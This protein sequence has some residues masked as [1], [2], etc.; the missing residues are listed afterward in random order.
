MPVST[1]EIIVVIIIL[2]IICDDFGA[3]LSFPRAG[4]SSLSTMNGKAINSTSHHII[5]KLTI[6]CTIVIGFPLFFVRKYITCFI[7][8]K[9]QI[10]YN[11]PLNQKNKATIIGFLAPVLWS[12]FALLA[13]KAGN[14]APFQLITISFSCSFF[15][16]LLIWKK[17]NIHIADFFKLPFKYWAIGI[18]GIFGFN[19]LYTIALKS[20][21]GAA[22]IFL[23][24]S[25]WPV[26]LIIFD[27]IFLKEHLK[28]WH[29][30]G[31]VLGFCGIIFIAIQDGFSGFHNEFLIPY[32]TALAAAIIWASYSILCKKNPAI[33]NNMVG[34]YTGVGAVLAFF[35]HLFFEKT[36]DLSISQII[37]VVLIGIGPSG[38]AYYAWNYGMRSGDIRA[39]SSF[40]FISALG[41]VILLILFGYAEFSWQ[42]A[43]ASILIIG[44]AFCGNLG[45]FIKNKD[46]S[47]I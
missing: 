28:S 46:Y 27:R 22:E 10:S 9:L 24:A 7:L 12:L 42:I 3:P 17:Q 19:I 30:A 40:S 23:L 5:I 1:I 37:P 44:G 39:I 26:F 41:A 4:F 16:S 34:C 36:S 43:F 45:V 29:I 47:T 8:D 38:L 18:F 32:I 21:A 11:M 2:P 35:C 20:G 13:I 25:T 33:P 6:I 31:V 15:M 14:I